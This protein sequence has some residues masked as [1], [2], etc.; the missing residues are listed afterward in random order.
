MD[1]YKIKWTRLQLEIFRYLGIKAGQD[2]NLRGLA[3]PLKV[4]PTAVSNALPELEKEGLISVKRS[5]TMNL[6]SIKFNRDSQKAIELKRAENLKM[7]YES[8]LADFLRENFPGCAIILFGSYSRGD[9][10]FSSD[11]DV[12]VVGTKGKEIELAKFDKLLERT[13]SINFYPSFKD[14]HNNLRNNILNGIV[15]GG[16]VET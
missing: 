15:L 7:I 2:F 3:R 1:M 5:E 4:S 8:G 13:I 10:I 11:I 12:A 6:M 16:S 14:I 9:D